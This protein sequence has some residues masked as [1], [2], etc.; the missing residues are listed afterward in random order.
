MAREIITVNTQ[1]G[2]LP[3]QLQSVEFPTIED[4]VRQLI[5]ESAFA[6]KLREPISSDSPFDRDIKDFLIKV[7][8]SG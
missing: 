8:V 7:S 1:V 3:V 5:M 6:R 2:T 4:L